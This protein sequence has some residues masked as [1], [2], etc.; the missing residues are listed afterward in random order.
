AID[1]AI[2]RGR[3]RLRQRASSGP[4]RKGERSRLH[5]PWLS[6][7]RYSR[8]MRL[9]EALRAGDR[10]AIVAPSSPFPRAQMLGG[11]AWLAQRYRISMHAD[12]F[13]RTGYL[14]G[15]DERRA[16]ELARAMRDPEARAIF[17]AR[18]GYGAT[19]IVSR[20]PW[21]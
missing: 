3:E 9:P 15:D 20:L 21:D 12:A 1:H 19:R 6:T 10:V 5:A 7:P 11:L 17:V 14:A 4:R 16:R 8:G 13:S 18:G 2:E